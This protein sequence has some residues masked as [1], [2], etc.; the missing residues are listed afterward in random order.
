MYQ[1]G[2]KVMQH[3]TPT[4]QIERVLE[5]WIPASDKG[6]PA[7]V[8]GVG[9]Q[10]TPEGLE[11]VYTL[12]DGAG[13]NSTVPATGIEAVEDWPFDKLNEE[14]SALMKSAGASAGVRSKTMKIF[15]ELHQNLER[16][17]LRASKIWSTSQEVEPRLY[18]YF[19]KLSDL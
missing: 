11:V 13:N 3:P 6:I 10:A 5:H 14:I 9:L 19:S 8:I 12:V 16:I 18:E 7:V 4:E 2:Q 1:I 17:H 15:D